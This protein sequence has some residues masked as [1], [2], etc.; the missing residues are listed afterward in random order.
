MIHIEAVWLAVD[1]L[2]MRLGTEAALARVVTVFGAARPH[3]AYLMGL[4]VD[5][6]ALTREARL[7]RP[8][9]TALQRCCVKTLAKRNFRGGRPLSAVP[10]VDPGPIWKADFRIAH[11]NAKFSPSLSRLQA[12][13]TL[14][15]SK[16]SLGRTIV[17]ART[18]PFR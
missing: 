11:A 3:H 15:G 10:I 5:N 7:H 6:S 2:D 16:Q 8:R 14:T 1:P 18:S 12:E 9:K 4:T 13:L 17:G